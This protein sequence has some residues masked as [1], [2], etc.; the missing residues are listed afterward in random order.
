MNFIFV[1]KESN[2]TEIKCNDLEA[3]HILQFQEYCLKKALRVA[4]IVSSLHFVCAISLFCI[5]D[6]DNKI[7]ANCILNDILYFK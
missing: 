6:R 3:L 4:H 7:H 2:I 1:K 5:R